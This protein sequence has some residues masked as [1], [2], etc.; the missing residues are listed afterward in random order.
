MMKFLPEKLPSQKC[1]GPKLP[2][3]TCH[4]TR[5]PQESQMFDSRMDLNCC[6]EPDKNNVQLL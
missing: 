5:P 1:R 4:V 6:L 2:Q 3:L